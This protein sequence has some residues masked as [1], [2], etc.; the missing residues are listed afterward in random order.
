MKLILTALLSIT[1][2]SGCASGCTH[3]CI[4]GIGPGNKTFDQVALYHDRTD[5]CQSGQGTR[6]REELARPEGYT[7]PAWCG[8]GRHRTSPVSVYNQQGQRILTVK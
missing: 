3:A 6:T 8:A 7:T 2:L 5:P 4:F 1:A